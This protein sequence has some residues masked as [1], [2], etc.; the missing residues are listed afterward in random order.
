MEEAPLYADDLYTKKGIGLKRAVGLEVE[1]H[2]ERLGFECW[3]QSNR[4][5]KRIKLRRAAGG[6]FLQLR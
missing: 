4:R 1:E 5:E 6:L 3:A 2:R